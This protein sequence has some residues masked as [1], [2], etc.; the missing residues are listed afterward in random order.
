M[1]FK[2]IARVLFVCAY[3]FLPLPSFASPVLP[4]VTG[5]AGSVVSLSLSESDAMSISGISLSIDYDR[6]LFTLNDVTAGS[7]LNPAVSI[8]FSDVA[9]DSALAFASFNAPDQLPASA[10]L[11]NFLFLI[12][13]STQTGAYSINFSCAWG[14]DPCDP[15]YG[16]S[17][18]GQIVV[19]SQQP[20][21]LPE[22]GMLSMLL[23]GASS[24]WLLRLKGNRRR[25]QS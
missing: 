15:D 13:S 8:F 7:D 20:N 22:P 10:N 11:L 21:N 14:A 16:P 19:E 1:D 25:L 9:P 12:N 3:I 18:S 5:T 6:T 23:L 17:F 4:T 2:K 24:W